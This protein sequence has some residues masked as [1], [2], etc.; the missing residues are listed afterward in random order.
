MKP[1][2]DTFPLNLEGNF[3]DYNL[4]FINS[5]YSKWKDKFRPVRL[6]LIPPPDCKAVAAPLYKSAVRPRVGLAADNL[7]INSSILGGGGVGN[8]RGQRPRGNH[9]GGK[10]KNKH[11]C[12]FYVH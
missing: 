5:V 3:F 8:K 7:I 11:Q 2:R 1:F 6:A 9:S 10:A 12:N 4:A